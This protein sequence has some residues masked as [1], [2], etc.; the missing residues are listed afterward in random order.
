MIVLLNQQTNIEELP[1]FP[2][3]FFG[4]VPFSQ[5]LQAVSLVVPWLFLGGFLVGFLVVPCRSLLLSLVGFIGCSLLLLVG[6]LGC[7]LLVSL[8][9][10]CWCS[11][12]SCCSLVVPCWFPCL[13]LVG[14]LV[15]IPGCTLLVSLV[16]CLFLVGF[17]VALVVP[18]WFPWLFFVGFLV[19]PCCSLLFLVGVLV[20]FR[21]GFLVVLLVVLLVI[22]C[23]FPW[24]FLV[25][26]SFSCFLRGDNRVLRQDL[27]GF[28]LHRGGG[29]MRSA[30]QVPQCSRVRGRLC[31]RQATWT[32]RMGS[33]CE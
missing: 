16:A 21:V 9:V 27:R 19:V 25:G 30:L 23:W 31:A 3:S 28:A 32:R 17:L 6:F 14:F 15:G 22:P 4:C 8:L 20:G 24:L 12:C 26:F 7:F 5:T 11:C 33:L 29:R 18:C 2:Q 1:S 13:F 10:A